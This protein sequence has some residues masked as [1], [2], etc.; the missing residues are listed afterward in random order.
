MPNRMAY[1]G[2]ESCGCVVAS[3]L[4]TGRPRAE[5]ARSVAEF[6]R[7]GLVIERVTVGYVREHFCMD[8][9][10]HKL[11]QAQLALAGGERELG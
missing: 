6:I 1:I 8:G 5:V 11:H 7:E 3:V 10:P 4:D 2:R 9:C